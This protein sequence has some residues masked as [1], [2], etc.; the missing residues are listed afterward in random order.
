M[1]AGSL[2]LS[3]RSRLLLRWE[4]W[5]KGLVWGGELQPISEHIKHEM[6]IWHLNK[7]AE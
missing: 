3:Q 4:R 6:F 7:Y 2:T 5:Q 1:T